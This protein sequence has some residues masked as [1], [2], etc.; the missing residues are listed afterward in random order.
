MDSATDTQNKQGRENLSV[1][2]LQ[3]PI[4]CLLSDVYLLHRFLTMDKCFA[5]RKFFR[6]FLITAVPGQWQFEL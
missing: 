1:Y 2:L 3:C 4:F 6:A 5:G